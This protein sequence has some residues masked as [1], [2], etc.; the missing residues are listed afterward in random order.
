MLRPG[1]CFLLATSLTLTLSALARAEPP[2]RTD[3][4]GDPLPPGAIVRM[5]THRFRV[6]SSGFDLSPDGK[7]LALEAGDGNINLC[8]PATGSV[9]HRLR[10]SK[11]RYFDI[12]GF[13]PDS[14][15]LAMRA[16]SSISVWE[17]ATGK[18]LWSTPGIP[19]GFPE[20]AFTADGQQIV[21][22]GQDHTVRLREAATGKC[23]RTHSQPGNPK[24][25]QVA[26]APGGR[27]LAAMTDEYTVCLWDLVSGKEL[28]KLPRQ[29][30]RVAWLAWSADAQKLASVNADRRSLHLWN[31]GAGTVR[32]IAAPEEIY[33]PSLTFSGEGKFLAV[34]GESERHLHVW[35]AATGQT[36]LTID[37]E[38]RRNRGGLMYLGGIT[39]HA[40]APDGKTLAVA[41]AEEVSLW[42]LA[43][44]KQVRRLTARVQSESRNG[45]KFSA[46]GK[47]LA[48]QDGVAVRFWDPASGRA[49]PGPAGHTDE[50][51]CLAFS[52]DGSR[53]ASAGLD[54]S[55]RLWETAT[56]KQLRQF[57]GHDG[58]VFELAL[59]RDAKTLASYANLGD[60]QVRV[61]DTA[62]GRQMFQFELVP[63][64]AGK[65]NLGA[66][67]AFSADGSTLAAAA[68]GTSTM[69]LCG[70]AT[71]K[72]RK[73]DWPIETHP[74]AFSV[75]GKSL[76]F[77][78]IELPEAE[79]PSIKLVD[80]I[81]GEGWLTLPVQCQPS[82][83]IHLSPDNRM[84]AIYSENDIALWEVATGRLVQHFKAKDHIFAAM[85][86]TPD[87]RVLAV[88][89]N[90]SL[91]QPFRICDLFADEN[92][93]VCAEE[94]GYF[95]VF[96]FSPDGTRLATG[97]MDGTTLLWDLARLRAKGEASAKR[98]D[99][100]ALVRLWADLATG[101]APRA[102]QAIRALRLAPADAVPFL[103]KHLEPVPEERYSPLIADLDDDSFRVREAAAEGLAQLGWRAEPALRGVLNTKP[104]L[105]VRRRVEALLAPLER[106][107]PPAEVLRQVRAIQVLEQID[108]PAAR[109]LLERLAGGA[110]AARLTR[111]ARAALERLVRHPAS[112]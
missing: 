57:A 22:W 3:L 33:P 61:W 2:V 27:F 26:V 59:S 6:S 12:I 50:V 4:Y 14:K 29:K 103:A 28:R 73:V 10:G 90:L 70:V 97:N 44:R 58:W 19:H 92:M 48:V 71:G 39:A 75:A 30:E 99:A 79:E 8:D 96:L 56:G 106:R 17:V 89:E 24:W 37:G 110:S 77:R 47:V 69:R 105:E 13:S 85:T 102:Y 87:G 55:V 65:G 51:R 84:L 9:R 109:Q 67:L 34:C 63:E 68:V 16:D 25:N 5:G 98:L 91:D 74:F 15:L 100:K 45:L 38:P 49:L 107:P 111:E 40:F 54:G 72:E 11:E 82:M 86:I 1:R 43:T 42:D 7:V 46:D 31:V 18:R 80:F 93:E 81:S 104:R 23:L 112:P 60:L 95:R 41:N 101:D 32:S 62:T 36:L 35:S 66:A 78:P 76:A 21:T 108:M 20:C 64:P 94:G 53:L 83:E 52:A 88:E